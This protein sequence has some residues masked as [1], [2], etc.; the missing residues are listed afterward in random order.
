MI[1]RA[2][3]VELSIKFIPYWK[4]DF[5]LDV[6]SRY[7]DLTIPLNSKGSRMINA[8]NKT[9]DPAPATPQ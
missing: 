7:K 5:L 1:G 2:E 4:Y 9:I 3:D 8:I 6:Q